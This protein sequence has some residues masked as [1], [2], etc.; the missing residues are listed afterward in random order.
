VFGSVMET[1]LATWSC[2]KVF[3]YVRTYLI[4]NISH[5]VPY[6]ELLQDYSVTLSYGNRV[7][8]FGL[9]QQKPPRH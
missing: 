9:C 3:T 1:K 2:I 7:R 5:I 6:R 8:L 4:Y